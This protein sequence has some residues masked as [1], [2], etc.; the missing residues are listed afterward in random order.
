MA[1]THRSYRMDDA[2]LSRLRAW[3]EDHGTTEA[4]ALR[5]LLAAALDAEEQAG[6]AEEAGEGRGAAD[7]DTLAML[8]EHIRDLRATISTLTA[9]LREKDDQLAR[10][11]TLADHAQALQAAHAQTQLI[12]ASDLAKAAPG[13]RLRLARWIGGG[14]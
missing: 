12:E 3:A 4:D 9:Q 14:E 1:A 2:L 5:R 13:W 11:L 7:P 8:G 10:A 6:D